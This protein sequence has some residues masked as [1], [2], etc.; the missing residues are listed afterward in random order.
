MKAKI[1]EE[2]C[3]GCGA[4]HYSAQ[5]YIEIDGVAK[6]TFENCDSEGFSAVPA[7][8]LDAIKEAAS[9]CPTDAIMISE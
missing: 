9:V 2:N 5:N 1:I 6:F 7:D 8:A 4:C 3:I